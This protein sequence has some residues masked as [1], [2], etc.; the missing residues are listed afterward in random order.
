MSSCNFNKSRLNSQNGRSAWDEL[1]D[2]ASMRL[3]II[4]LYCRLENKDSDCLEHVYSDIEISVILSIVIVFKSVPN[5][6]DEKITVLLLATA[7]VRAGKIM[8]KLIVVSVNITL[9]NSPG[10][11]LNLQKDNL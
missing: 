9:L 11:F 7:I 3:N 4:F 6:S 2:P 8:N 1:E 10:E 5:I